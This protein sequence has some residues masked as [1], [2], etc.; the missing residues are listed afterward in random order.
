[1]WRTKKDYGTILPAIL[2][3]AKLNQIKTKIIIAI[4]KKESAKNFS[5]N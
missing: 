3:F 4:N 5:K 1:M 2:T